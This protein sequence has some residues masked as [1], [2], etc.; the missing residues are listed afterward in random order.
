MVPTSRPQFSPS[1]LREHFIS[2]SAKKSHGC[3]TEENVVLIFEVT[4]LHL[5]YRNCFLYLCGEWRYVKPNFNFKYEIHNSDQDDTSQTRTVQKYP[6]MGKRR[7][8]AALQWHHGLWQV[9]ESFEAIKRTGG[10]G[11]NKIGKDQQH[12]WKTQDFSSI[13]NF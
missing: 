1:A 2:C 8:T 3:L 5:C 11:G 7:E 12:G 13:Q 4:T 9:T 10:Q 6:F